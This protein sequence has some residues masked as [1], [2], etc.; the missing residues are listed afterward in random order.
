MTTGYYA[1]DFFKKKL[2]KVYTTNSCKS[3]QFDLKRKAKEKD[4]L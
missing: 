4:K 1:L 2:Y 3:T